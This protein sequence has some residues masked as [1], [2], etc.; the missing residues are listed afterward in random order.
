MPVVIFACLNDCNKYG[1][2]PAG[3]AHV[4]ECTFNVLS[5]HVSTCVRAYVHVRVPCVC[6]Y[7]GVRIY[8]H[9]RVRGTHVCVYGVGVCLCVCI[10]ACVYVGRISICVFQTGTFFSHVP[11]MCLSTSVCMVSR[12]H[13]LFV[14]LLLSCGGRRLFSRVAHVCPACFPLPTY[15]WSSFLFGGG[16]FLN[17]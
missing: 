7:A 10:R 4:E 8:G 5:V 15:V 1:L 17:V 3:H 14:L 12:L 13:Y 16:H 11:P 9:M 2:R 6:V